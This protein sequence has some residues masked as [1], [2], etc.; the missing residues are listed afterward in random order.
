M[1]ENSV[2]RDSERESTVRETVGKGKVVSKCEWERTQ[3]ELTG[4][5]HIWLQWG[6]LD[7][8]CM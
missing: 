4:H 2:A 1:G 8:C 3:G 7:S 6:Y 5:T